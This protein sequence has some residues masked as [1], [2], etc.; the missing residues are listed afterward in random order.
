MFRRRSTL[1]SIAFLGLVGLS[2]GGSGEVGF[3]RLLG[4]DSAGGVLRGH[5]AIQGAMGFGFLLVLVLIEEEEEEEE[6]VKGFLREWS[7]GFLGVEEEKR[8][9]LLAPH[10]CGNSWKKDSGLR[11]PGGWLS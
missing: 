6:V 3:G 11:R 1:R 5:L 9:A 7:V 8:E 2:G 4:W 10:V